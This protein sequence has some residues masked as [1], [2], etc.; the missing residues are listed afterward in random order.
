MAMNNGGA[1]KISI[2][3]QGASV[4]LNHIEAQAP[5]VMPNSLKDML[6]RKK[7]APIVALPAP[8]APV[9]VAKPVEKKEDGLSIETSKLVVDEK[10][11]L[12]P[13]AEKT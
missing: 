2:A 13:F 12:S 6:L 3:G 8:A 5:L 1:E 10:E 7:T 9:V 11:I 4:T